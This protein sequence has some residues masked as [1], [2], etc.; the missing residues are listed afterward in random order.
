MLWRKY[1]YVEQVDERDCGVAALSMILENFGSH[2]SLAHLRELAKTDMEG[3]TALGIV[4]AAESLG[5]S[6]KS[7]KTTVDLLDVVDIPFPFIVHVIKN[8]QTFHYYVIYK[9]SKK[10]VYIG[11]PDPDVGR[12]KVRREKF[13][14]EWS[15]VAFFFSEKVDFKKHKEPKG[16]LWDYLPILA[17]QKKLILNIILASLVLTMISIAGSYYF[18]GIIDNFI[19]NLATS[20]LGTI[21]VGL[22]FAYVFEQVLSYGQNLLLSILGQRLSINIV[23]SYIR[24]IY[25]LPLS[26][27]STRR[28][29]E[30]VSRFTDANTIID[31]LASTILSAFLDIWVVFVLGMVLFLQ[32]STLFLI[33]LCAIPMYVAVIMIFVKLFEQYN[34][35]TMQSN[36]ILNSSIIEDINGI[37]TIKSLNAEEQTYDRVDREFVDLLKKSFS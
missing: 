13:L 24:H 34:Q 5:L 19:P 26:F 9:I 8:K 30:I 17:K 15:G 28:T 14:E 37:E 2:Y 11:D 4:S 18:Q 29:G 23:L 27:F 21:S 10:Y 36:A 35:E 6:A 12:T 22:I 3:T 31:A 33:T 16:S 32:D 25:E 7:I 1:P 20:L